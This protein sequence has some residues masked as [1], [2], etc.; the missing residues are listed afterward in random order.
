MK[1]WKNK[2]RSSGYKYRNI[3][4]FASPVKVFI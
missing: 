3:L 2:R 4:K 1:R